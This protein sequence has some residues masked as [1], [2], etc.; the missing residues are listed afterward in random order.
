M[1][2]HRQI[3]FRRSDQVWT[4]LGVIAPGVALPKV[5]GLSVEKET[6]TGECFATLGPGRCN[7]Q[8]AWWWS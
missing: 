2:K 1:K 6:V 8:W 3:E 4:D 7:F 5:Q